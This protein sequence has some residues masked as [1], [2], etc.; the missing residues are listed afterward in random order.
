MYN[1]DPSDENRKDQE[2]GTIMTSTGAVFNDNE[3]SVFRTV[4]ADYYGQRKEA[5]GKMFQIEKEIAYLTEY[6]K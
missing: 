5:K 1:V 3:D 2:A 4:L 6:I